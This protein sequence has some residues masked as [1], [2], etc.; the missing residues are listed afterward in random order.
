MLKKIHY[1][2]LGG[3]PLPRSVE[4]CINSWKKH[5]PDWEI[6]QW[7]EKNFPVEEYKWVQEAIHEKK[8]AFAA[9]FI[10]LYVLYNYGGAYCDT[11]V[12]FID[13]IGK[14][15]TQKLVCGIE[16]HLIGTEDIKYLSPE[17]YD[18]RT[19]QPISHFGMQTGFLYCEPKHPFI[20]NC[21]N[22]VY[23]NGNRSF[24]KE[25][26][27][28]DI[29]VIDGALIHELKSFGFIFKDET[30][31]LNPDIV[32]Y[33]SNIF[34]TRKTQDKESC[35]IHWFDQSW[36]TDSSL[37]GRIKRIIKK[38]LFPLYRFLNKEL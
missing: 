13:N 15:I 20:Y 30:Q 21:I 19:G 16:N 1:C 10:R 29:I 2:W 36:V 14:Y 28:H 26:G 5:C 37:K 38:H 11:D 35:L 27:S 33:K 17:G 31:Y 6:I 24:C 18:I 32:I 3:K 34:A 8:Y 22:N 12:S 9:D 4:S 23:Q 7:N 25:D